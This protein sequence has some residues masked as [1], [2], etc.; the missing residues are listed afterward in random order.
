V[1]G[2]LSDPTLELHDSQ[3]NLLESNNDWIDSP[4]K[5]ALID[6]SL[7]PTNDKESAII[8]PLAPANYTAIIR[9][10]SNA[11][12]IGLVEIYDLD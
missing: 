1:P 8:L 7:A 6:S 9:G 3:G 11:T 5:Q 10:V 4:H 12:G 2:A